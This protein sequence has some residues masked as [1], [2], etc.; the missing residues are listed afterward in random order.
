MERANLICPYNFRGP[1]VAVITQQSMAADSP[2]MRARRRRRHREL[3]SSAKAAFFLVRFDISQ[4]GVT[5]RPCRHPAL[6][7]GFVAGLP[8]VCTE[9][10]LSSA[11]PGLHVGA[12]PTLLPWQGKS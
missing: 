10:S 5:S 4:P 6:L 12:A 11:A 3:L 9:R 7:G 2:F 1:M 8:G